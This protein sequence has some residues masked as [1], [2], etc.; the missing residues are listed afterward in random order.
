MKRLS[1]LLFVIILGLSSYS[2]SRDCGKACPDLNFLIAFRGN[3]D[4]HFEYALVSEV[5][6]S[7]SPSNIIWINQGG[8]GILLS[9][10]AFI[11]T[12]P[13]Y[14]LE[15][16]RAKITVYKHIHDPF[17]G[18]DKPYKY[19]IVQLNNLFYYDYPI[20]GPYRYCEYYIPYGS[21]CFIE[22]PIEG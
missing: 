21:W 14:T 20:N 15:F 2:Q 17:G 8:S 16:I 10:K 13:C 1:L 7:T 22:N 18:Y 3:W 19:A 11:N 4:P 12:T 9:Y 6:S 5:S